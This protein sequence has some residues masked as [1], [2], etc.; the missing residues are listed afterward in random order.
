[1]SS[2]SSSSSRAASC[3]SGLADD[4]DASVDA[5]AIDA[6][7]SDAACSSARQRFIASYSVMAM[8]SSSTSYGI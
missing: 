6:E 7:S 8:T 3:L 4:G 1:L 2:S 5:D